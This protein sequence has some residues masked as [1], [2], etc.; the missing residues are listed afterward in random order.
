MFFAS[1]DPCP[2]RTHVLYG[3]S[4]PHDRTIARGRQ[5][6]IKAQ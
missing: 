6:G 3:L 5:T 2:R 1:Q 4:Q